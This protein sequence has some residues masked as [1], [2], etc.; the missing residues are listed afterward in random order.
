MEILDQVIK[1]LSD[2][3]GSIGIVMGVLFAIAKAAS[4]E[5]AGM[6]VGSIQKVV[7]M[8]ASIVVKVGQILSALSN[9]LGNMIKSDGLL[10]KK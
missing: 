7:D 8:I 2:N 5:K 4:N 6:I 10:G 9:I 3:S 1:V